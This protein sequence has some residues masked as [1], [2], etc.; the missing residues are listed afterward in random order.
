[1]ETTAIEVFTA[2]GVLL[3]NV[4]LWILNGKFDLLK[5]RLDAVERAHNTHVNAP[6]LHRGEAPGI[7]AAGPPTASLK[8]GPFEFVAVPRPD[9]RLVPLEPVPSTG[10][11]SMPGGDH[12]AAA[13][14]S[15][16]RRSR[17]CR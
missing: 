16:S 4:W 14:S 9:R 5:G 11:A 8:Q 3:A 10:R 12:S 13:T 6:G 7:G 1:M 2:G 17:A 15:R